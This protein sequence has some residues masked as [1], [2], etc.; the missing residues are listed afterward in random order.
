MSDKRVIM[1]HGTAEDWQK[2]VNFIPKKGEI[3]VYDNETTPSIKVGDGI[4]PVANLPFINYTISVEA[5]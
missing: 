3:I 4:T 1:K 2:A 5:E